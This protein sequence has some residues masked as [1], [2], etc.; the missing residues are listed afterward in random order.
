VRPVIVMLALLVGPALYSQPP[1]HGT[2]NIL[3]AN[4]NGMVL[5]TDSRASDQFGHKIHDRA[6]KLFQIDSVTVCSIAGFGTDPGPHG[7]LIETASGAIFSIVEGLAKS[8]SKLSFEDK[9]SVFTKTLSTQLVAVE[10]EYEYAEKSKSPR[11]PPQVLIMLFA[12]FDT[13]GSAA[14]AKATISVKSTEIIDSHKQFGSD[15]DIKIEPIDKGFAYLTAGVDQWAQ[16]RLQRPTAFENEMELKAYSQRFR[17]GRTAE[18]NLDQLER[19]ARYL[20]SDTSRSVSVV[21]GPIQIATLSNN[22]VQVTLPGNLI[23]DP[24]PYS[25]VFVFY[26]QV[27]DSPIFPM[28]MPARHTVFVNN[29]CTNAAFVLDDETYIGGKYSNCNFYFD[30]GDFYRDPTVEIT[31]GKLV[32]GPHVQMNSYFLDKA[33]TSM[34]ELTPMPYTD[35]PNAE[36]VRKRIWP[37]K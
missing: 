25:T 36:S 7:K 5:V 24:S 22:H 35:L 26:N 15:V 13:N 20:E 30:G 4:R 17:D 9:V 37:D 16:D 28:I 2:I 1:S 3:V 10:T 8:G 12:G 32:L 21:G 11:P 31:G 27:E 33:R 29:D 19:L 34:P 14:V 23:V 18:L 6:Q